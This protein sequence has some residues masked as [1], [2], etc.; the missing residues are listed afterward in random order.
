MDYFPRKTTRRSSLDFL[1]G[2]YGGNILRPDFRGIFRGNFTVK[3]AALWNKD[4]Q[5][6]RIDT[7]FKHEPPRFMPSAV[8]HATEFHNKDI[9]DIHLSSYLFSE[10]PNLALGDNSLSHYIPTSSHLRRH[11]ETQTFGGPNVNC[12]FCEA[13]MWTHEKVVVTPKVNY[14]VFSICCKQGMIQL[15]PT[16]ATSA[17]LE[18]LLHTQSGSL[19]QHFRDNIRIYNS[20]LQFTSLGG[21]IDATINNGSGPYIFRLNGQTHHR[22]GSLLP[23]PGQN[24]RYAQLYIYDIA[25][26]ICNRIS[27]VF[28][29]SDVPAINTAIVEGILLMLNESNEIVKAFR[30][31]RDIYEEGQTTTLRLRLLSAR[32]R[33]DKNYAPP[34]GSEIAAL[35]VG[36]IGYGNGD[37]DVIVEHRTEGLK[38]ISILHPLYMPMQYPLL[39]SHGEDGYVPGIPFVSSPVKENIKR[40]TVSMRE[41]YAYKIQTRHVLQNTLLR[42]GRLFQQFITDVFSATD[43]ERLHYIRNNQKKLRADMYKDIRDVM[44]RGDVQGKSIRKRVILPASFTGGSRY[45]FQNYQDALAICRYY[46]LPD[47]FITFTCNAYWNE[48]Q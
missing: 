47:L 24:A 48:I 39:F 36:D 15:P 10:Q 32:E 19:Y 17:F 42:G 45:L 14:P 25:N 43:E 8:Q 22:L 23:L 27:S 4:L 2:K 35:I 37:R 13:N 5:Q 26:E 40:K 7:F 18:H 11:Y 16:R 34:S 41:Y 33:N 1:V 30:M 46:G 38:R 9:N 21:K 6:E 44:H 3:F 12:R 20:L 28:G 29:D 31:A